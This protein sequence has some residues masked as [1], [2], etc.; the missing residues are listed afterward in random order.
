[1]YVQYVC[2][3]I[4]YKIICVC[5]VDIVIR[6]SYT[7]CNAGIIYNRPQKNKDKDKTK[8]DKRF[9]IARLYFLFAFIQLFLYLFFLCSMI[10]A[11]FSFIIALLCLVV[12][13]E[14]GH[15]ILAKRAGVTVHEFSVGMGKKLFTFGRDSH[16]TV[17]NFRAFPI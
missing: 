3:P 1:M 11:I 15:Y 4:C 12:A 6:D 17:F 10:I 8:N 5:C 7:L 2:S 14:W 13:H 16:G 9:C